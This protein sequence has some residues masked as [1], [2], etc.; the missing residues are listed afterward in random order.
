MQG[1]EMELLRSGKDQEELKKGSKDWKLKK[2][3][4][5]AGSYR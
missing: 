4:N 1:L 3:R 2:K 5:Q